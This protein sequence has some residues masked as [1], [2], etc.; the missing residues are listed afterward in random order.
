[1][2]DCVT[3]ELAKDGCPVFPALIIRRLRRIRT[4]KS[5]CSDLRRLSPSTTESEE[6][7]Q[8]HFLNLSHL[9]NLRRFVVLGTSIAGIEKQHVIAYVPF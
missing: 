5:I 7:S 9:C 8:R 3:C 6:N 1:M 4:E 2:I